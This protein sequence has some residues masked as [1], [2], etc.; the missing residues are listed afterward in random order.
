MTSYNAPIDEILFSMKA[1]KQLDEV[2]QLPGCEDLNEELVSGVLEAAGRFA[3][4]AIAPLNLKGDR[5]GCLFENGVVRTPGASKEVY[6]QFVENGWNSL[7]FETDYGGQGL[8]WLL[9]TAVQEMWQSASM[10]FSL[11]PLLTQSGVELLTALGTP[12]QKD[13]YLTR[14]IS[15][16]WTATMNLTEPQAGSDVGAIRTVAVK[17]GEHYL[18]KG[19]KIFITYGEHDLSENIIHFVL[20]RLEGAPAG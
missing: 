17:N 4:E 6:R 16:E 15:G 5:T 18:I 9:G 2:L 10:G 3:G 20:A 14:L 11:C 13:L 8:P 19:Q 12:E 1:C 7:P